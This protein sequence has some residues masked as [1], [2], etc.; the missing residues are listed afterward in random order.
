MVEFA[1]ERI[2]LRDD[3][4]HTW[5]QLVYL[6]GSGFRVDKDKDLRES[7]SQHPAHGSAVIGVLHCFVL[8]LKSTHVMQVICQ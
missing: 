1:V 4:L 7:R 3:V 2:P 6:A 8:F 5:S